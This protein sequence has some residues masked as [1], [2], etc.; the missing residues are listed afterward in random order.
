MMIGIATAVVAIILLSCTMLLGN[1]KTHLLQDSIHREK[2]QTVDSGYAFRSLAL[3]NL[4][5]VFGAVSLTTFGE[6]IAAGSGISEIKSVLN[7]VKIPRT[8]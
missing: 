5:L 7:G 3:F 1:F 2:L 4:V 8:Y 6:R